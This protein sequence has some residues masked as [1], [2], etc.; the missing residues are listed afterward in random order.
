MLSLLLA[1]ILAASPLAGHAV[2]ARITYLP[3][4]TE[5][6]CAPEYW[7]EKM[8]DTQSLLA[9]LPEIEAFNQNNYQTPD[10][11][12]IDM[13]NAPRYF[14]AQN[15]YRSLWAGTLRDASDVMGSP[16]YDAEGNLISGEDLMRIMDNIGGDNAPE[17]KKIR[18]GICVR[19]T[20]MLW[21]PGDVFTTDEKGDVEYN[22]YQLTGVRVNEPL[23][24]KAVSK[25]G[26]Y[27]YCDMDCC[28]GWVPSAD[29]A[30]CEDR[31]QWQEAWDVPCGEAVVVTEGK[32]YLESSIANPKS[33]DVLLT[34][35]TVLRK[36]NEEEYDSALTGRSPVHN[37]PVWLPVR[38]ED[39]SYDRIIA[40]ISQNRNVSEGYLPLTTENIL[41]VAF[42]MLGD[43]YGW[44]GMLNSADCSAYIRDIYRCFGLNLPRNT[45]WQCA[46]PVFKYDVTEKSAEEKKAILDTLPAGAVLYFNGHEMMYL[47]HENGQYY[48]ISALGTMKNPEKEEALRVRSVAINSLETR[49]MSGMSW[50]EALTTMLVPYLP[51]EAEEDAAEPAQSPVPGMEDPKAESLVVVIQDQGGENTKETGSM[52]GQTES[53][54]L[55]DA[56]M[57]LS[58]FLRKAVNRYPVLVFDSALDELFGAESMPEN[59]MS[60]RDIPEADPALNLDAESR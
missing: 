32:V 25:D 3:D 12:M 59:E 55:T 53:M 13:R 30:L 29:V 52:E 46:M 14:N 9:G 16:Y 17:Q 58:M 38:R 4:V 15:F 34:M 56:Q 54:A 19:R 41:K 7:L 18:Y 37:Y 43:I 40:L 39:G 50:M 24:V 47:G 5:Q 22:W 27:Y 57:Q 28:S 44:G 51:Q 35:G 21:M 45:T 36:V 20:D 26:A 60:G 1:S 23:L 48:V 10:C 11:M 2:S 31:T 6:M 42:T 8:Q 49:R 33:S